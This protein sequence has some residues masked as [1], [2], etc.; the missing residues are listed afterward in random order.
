M[1]YRNFPRVLLIL[2]GFVALTLTPI[3]SRSVSASEHWQ[4]LPKYPPMPKANQ[5]G[6]AN[7]NG[8][9]MYYATYGKGEPILF[10]H[11]GLGHGDIFGYQ[12]VDFMKTNLVIIADSRGHGRS[13]RNEA[14]FGYDLM[15]SDYLGLLDHLS[16]KSVDLVGWSDGGIIGI[17]IAMNNPERVRKVFAHAA[18]VTTD[19]VNPTVMQNKVFNDFINRNGEDYKRMSKT[20][21]Q[22]DDFVAQIS[23]MWDTQPNWSAEM[24]GK[25]KTPIAVVIGEHDEAVLIPHTEKMA[26]MIPGSKLIILKGVSHFAPVQ[27]PEGYNAAIRK[28]FSEN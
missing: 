5:S 13:T 26:Q 27:D 14:P 16:I 8:I 19:G 4:T 3:L 20:P 10:I 17:N 21:D 24:L 12:V 2:L 23:K 7:I 25:I 28:F 6:F 11:S 15:S 9:E 1:N 18:N 22:Y